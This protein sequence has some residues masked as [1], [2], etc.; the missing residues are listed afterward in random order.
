MLRRP[1]TNDPNVHLATVL[2]VDDTA[3]ARFLV[4]STLRR[5]GFSTLVAGNGEMALSTLLDRP[6]DAIVTDLEM[7]GM[8]GEQLVQAVRSHKNPH[9]RELPIIVCSS[10]VDSATLETLASLGVDAV[11]PKPVEV[12]LLVEQALKLFRIA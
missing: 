12:R 6:P 4:A 2:V 8:G 9:I 3:A 11:V 5:L 10:K 1:E 7:P